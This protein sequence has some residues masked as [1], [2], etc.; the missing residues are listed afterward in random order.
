MAFMAGLSRQLR[1]INGP[2]GSFSNRHNK[3]RDCASSEFTGDTYRVTKAQVP[4][5]NDFQLGIKY[6]DIDQSK[7]NDL[8]TK[9]EETHPKQVGGLIDVLLKVIEGI[10]Y[11]DDETLDRE[12]AEYDAIEQFHKDKKNQFVSQSDGLNPQSDGLN[13][14]TPSKQNPDQQKRSSTLMNM[15]IGGKTVSEH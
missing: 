15:K 5:L 9:G 8:L 4:Y 14:R 11:K 13:P 1:E 12:Q 3:S 6:S 7:L 10:S 2:H